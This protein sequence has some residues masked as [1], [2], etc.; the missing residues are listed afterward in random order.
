MV[1]WGNAHHG[2]F[3]AQANQFY[4]WPLIAIPEGLFPHPLLRPQSTECDFILSL[5]YP[6]YV[7][8][9]VKQFPGSQA[10]SRVVS[11]LRIL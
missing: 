4:P 5:W 2:R 10:H 7:T 11:L 6:Q 8:P 3:F 9:A 1:I